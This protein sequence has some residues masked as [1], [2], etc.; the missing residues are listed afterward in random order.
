MRQNDPVQQNKRGRKKNEELK[1]I[2]QLINST[3]WVRNVQKEKK[4]KVKNTLIQKDN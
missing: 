4:Q 2:K 3:A 1:T